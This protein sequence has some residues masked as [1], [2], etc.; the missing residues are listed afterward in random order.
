MQN[1]Y[2]HH[3]LVLIAEDELHTRLALSIIFKKAGFKVLTAETGRRALEKIIRID[4][5]NEMVNLLVSDIQMPD[6]SG[7]DLLS[8]LNKRQLSVPTILITGYGIN[9]IDQTLG[10]MKYVDIV[11]KPFEAD[12]I[13]QRVKRIIRA[14][15]ADSPG[16][17]I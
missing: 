13:L 17:M 4:Q 12:D 5:S 11:E 9:D 8:E 15:E 14:A 3:Y 7:I 10:T 16:K 2:N 6:L 1:K